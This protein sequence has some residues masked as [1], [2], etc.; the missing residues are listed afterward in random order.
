MTDA[1]TTRRDLIESVWAEAR[2]L[3]RRLEGTQRA[4]PRRRG[5]RLRDR[6]RARSLRP[7]PAAAAGD[8]PAITGHVAPAPRP[9]LGVAPGARGASGAFAAI[10][11]RGRQ[12][13]PGARPA[14]RHLLPRRRSPGAKPFVEVGDVVELG[15]TV[16]IVEAMKLMNEVGAPARPARSPRS[17]SRTA[18]R[19]SSSR[20]SMYLEPARV[21]RVFEKV[22]I[23]NRGEIALRVARACREL[24][25]KSVAVYS[26]A[27]A[28]SARR[29]VRRRGRLHRPAAAGQELPPHPEHHRRGAED[30]RRR[31]PPRLRLPLRGP[32]L[33]RDLRRQRHHLHRARPR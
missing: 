1:T 10:T 5:R 2:D 7:A 29:A 4:A 17:S 20:C 28:E 13:G 11:R 19:S 3:V 32:V 26:T 14:R 27:D 30:R 22:L 12:P 16:C 18:S 33:R 31:D 15:Q 6:D 21:V 9:G 8:A 23:A 25:V 24:G